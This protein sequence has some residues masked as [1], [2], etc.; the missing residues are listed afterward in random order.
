MT[1]FR[2]LSNHEDELLGTV[3]QGRLLDFNQ[4]IA[5]EVRLSGS[6]E[7]LRAFQYVQE[8]LQQFG[9]QTEL[10]FNEAYIS[11]PM[12]ASLRVG[13]VDYTCITHSMGASVTDLAGEVVY[14][15]G[16]KPQDLEGI[17]VEGKVLLVDGLAVPAV[18]KTVTEFGAK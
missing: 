12:K 7:E 1:G 11:L 14:A 3:D 6:S 10:L 8:Q 13:N 17:V 5:K 16:G 15:R 9:Y 4:N 18:V 2:A